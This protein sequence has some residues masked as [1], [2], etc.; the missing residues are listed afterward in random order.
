LSG[1]QVQRVALA[2]ALLVKPRVLILDEPTS[3]LDAAG[4]AEVRA[5]LL[6]LR[7][8]GDRPATLL[9]THSSAFAE[10]LA[11]RVLTLGT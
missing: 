6:R 7:A 8:A 10:G 2:R 5:S 3:A 9:I 4:E 1:G 11:D